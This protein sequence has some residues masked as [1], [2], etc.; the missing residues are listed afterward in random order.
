MDLLGT[1]AYPFKDMDGTYGRIIHGISIGED[2]RPGRN[3]SPASKPSEGRRSR[4]RPGREWPPRTCVGRGWGSPPTNGGGGGETLNVPLYYPP[5][6]A[7]HRN[8]LVHAVDVAKAASV[9]RV[10]EENDTLPT[11]FQYQNVPIGL[12]T[13]IIA[14][15]GRRIGGAGLVFAF[16]LGMS[17]PVGVLVFV[18]VQLATLY[19]CDDRVLSCTRVFAE[20]LMGLPDIVGADVP[21]LCVLGDGVQR[22]YG[23]RRGFGRPPSSGQYR[24]ACWW[25]G[26]GP[27]RR[28]GWSC[29]FGDGDC[30]HGFNGNDVGLP[31]G[32]CADTGSGRLFVGLD[33]PVVYLL[34]IAGAARQANTTTCPAGYP[35]DPTRFTTCRFRFGDGV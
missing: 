4:G 19:R 35:V 18:A 34:G 23:I 14:H 28:T 22:Y 33:R 3:G 27:I 9:S 15:P 21:G 6:P 1:C 26:G 12:T 20:T 16:L 11:A 17:Y 5:S 7:T 32:R 31:R 30:V 2:R 10:T 25:A 8:A 13:G 29:R 24:Y